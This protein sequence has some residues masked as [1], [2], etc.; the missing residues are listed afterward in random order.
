M[1]YRK[2]K[3]GAVIMHRL[4]T[5]NEMAEADRL[6]IESGRFSGYALMQRAGA[7]VAAVILER[8]PAAGHVDV[9]C[10]PGNNG[11]DG[12]VIASLLEQSGVDVRLWRSQAPKAGTDAALAADACALPVEELS[13][14][15]AEPGT[16]VVD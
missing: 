8:F 4:L 3:A 9:L 15:H 14:F 12:Y 6:T 11:G 16:L 10:G 2:M 7:A 5:P 1:C 13:E